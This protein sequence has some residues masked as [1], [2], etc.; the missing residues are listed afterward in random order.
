MLGLE[1]LFLTKF[2]GDTDS[3]GLCTTLRT[4]GLIHSEFAGTWKNWLNFSGM[5][6]VFLSFSY[7]S[8]LLRFT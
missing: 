6:N 3:S 7:I 2:P 5:V 1:N 4:T 8:R